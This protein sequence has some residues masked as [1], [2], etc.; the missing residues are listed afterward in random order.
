MIKTRN[1]AKAIIIKNG[2]MLFTKNRD[3][4]GIY[5]ILPGGGQEPEETL[6]DALKRECREEI[7]A[8]IEI[9][10]LQYIREFIE[11]NHPPIGCHYEP[12]QI[13]F[14]FLCSLVSDIT[15]EK[16]TEPDSFQIGAEWLELSRLAEYRTYPQMMN[17]IISSDGKFLDT[18]YLG[19]VG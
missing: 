19:D 11:K 2:K 8:E 13:E 4:L 1:S 12:H 14:M 9:G 16:G 7:G 5:Y 15:L 10:E 17:D 6:I 18:V 3:D